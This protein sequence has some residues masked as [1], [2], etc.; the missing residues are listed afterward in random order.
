MYIQ[1]VGVFQIQINIAYAEN[2][3][4]LVSHTTLSDFSLPL[5]SLEHLAN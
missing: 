3:A 1:A 5:Y 4:G 2:L